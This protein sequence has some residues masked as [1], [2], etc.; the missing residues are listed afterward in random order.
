MTDW[1]DW[2]FF[3]DRHRDLHAQI[4]DWCPANVGKGHEEDVDTECRKLVA[5]LGRAGILKL[6]VADGDK[7]PDVLLADKRQIVSG[8]P[9]CA[10]SGLMLRE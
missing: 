2:P 6:C 5:S 10:I 8:C 3:E 4:C 1:L 9:L 7:L